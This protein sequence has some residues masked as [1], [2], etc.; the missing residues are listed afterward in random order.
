MADRPTR[1]LLL[2]APGAGKGTQ[3]KRLEAALGVP[4][5]STGDML[6]EARAAETE[7][8]KR[9]GAAMDAGMLVPDEVVIGLV[10][11]RLARP[12][13][14][15]G[16]VFDGF[17]RTVAQAEALAALGASLETVL[18]IDVPEEDL[19][20]RITGRM[21][22]ASCGAPYHKRFSPPAVTGVCDVCGG[23]ELVVRPDD[24]EAVVRERLSQYHEQTAPLIAWYEGLGLLRRVDGSGAPEAVS[25]EIR[26]VL[27]LD[28]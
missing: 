16:F 5:I 26:E 19:V 17:P 27:E 25:E 11:E 20:E 22:C 6:R 24:T 15:E 14:R 12:D 2:G 28:R 9:A 7:L 10:A 13:C 23:T 1:L 8:G 4:Q 3:A 18:L 21:S